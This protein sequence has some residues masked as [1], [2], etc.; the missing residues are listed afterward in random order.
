MLE[1]R[2]VEERQSHMGTW[3]KP[4]ESGI[5]HDGD[6][7]RDFDNL[8]GRWTIHNKRLDRRLV[9]SQKWLEFEADSDV[10]PAL[11][12]I[13]NVEEYHA[14]FPDGKPVVGMTV[15]IFDPSTRLWSLYWADSRSGKLGPPVIGRFR[16]GVG[17]FLGD[18]LQDGVP[19]KVKF[20]WSDIT[21][22][23]ARWEQA[24]S[25]DGGTTWEWNWEMVF[26]R[27][28]EPAGQ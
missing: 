13:G 24:M 26:V 16:N 9:G 18:D 17:E 19:V 3:K 25:A 22:S 23:S 27:A 5:D 6:G 28:S 11:G 8:I 12:G 20:R 1:L 14:L 10:R 4:M 15:R 2:T 21:P 7:H